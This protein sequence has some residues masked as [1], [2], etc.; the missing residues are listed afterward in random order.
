MPYPPALSPAGVE[1]LAHQ[2]LVLPRE[3]QAWVLSVTRR[4]LSTYA[5]K[6]GLP[7]RIERRQAQTKH[8]DPELR[9]RCQVHEYVIFV[10]RCPKC[11][12]E[13]AA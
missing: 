8:P 7:H 9:R 3:D 10:G 4:T 5:R 13:Q 2:G 11:E 1:W 6:L 12:Q